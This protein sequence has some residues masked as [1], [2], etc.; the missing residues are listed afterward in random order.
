MDF[1]NFIRNIFGAQS[2]RNFN[3]GERNHFDIF[4]DP[5]QITRYFESEIENMLN[6]IFGFDNGAN[7]TGISA[8]SFA[9]PQRKTL[10]DNMLKPNND[11]M[12]LKIDT[13]LDGR[14][15]VDNFSNVWEECK[16][17][18][19]EI[20]RPTIIGR[21]MRKEYIRKPDGTIEQKQI[22]KDYEGNQETIVSHQTGDKIH[23]IITKIDKNGVETKTEDF[24][25]IS[26]YS[27]AL[28]KILSEIIIDDVINNKHL[29]LLYLYTVITLSI[30]MFWPRSVISIEAN[31]APRKSK[32]M[33]SVASLFREL[34][35]EL[36]VVE[37][38]PKTATG[39]RLS[40]PQGKGTERAS[41][42][43]F[44]LQVRIVTT[45]NEHGSSLATLN[46]PPRGKP[47]HIAAREQHIQSTH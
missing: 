35:I 47:P 1:W 20:L 29:Y 34:F 36:N 44:G 39:I 46:Q 3:K 41:V 10:R 11:Q 21:S 40:C 4:S 9:P 27:D 8:F 17:P 23:T 14:V 5:L 28:V 42:L 16:K 30:V 15:T 22:I 6:S 32:N 37:R 43:S 24:S 12:G 18:K 45:S 19:F 13:D 38:S 26:E 7:D 33:D 31:F 25:D 2:S